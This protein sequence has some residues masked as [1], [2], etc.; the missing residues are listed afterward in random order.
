MSN[1]GKMK[2]IYMDIYYS[3]DGNI[4]PEYD[5]QTYMFNR[6]QEQLEQEQFETD[7]SKLKKDK[8]NEN[9]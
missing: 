6:L 5:F 8:L 4:P 2:E 9:Q 3:M 1:M 7:V